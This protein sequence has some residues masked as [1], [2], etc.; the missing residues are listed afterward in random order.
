MIELILPWPP[1]INHYWRN[2][3]GRTIISREGRA[4]RAAVLSIIAQSGLQPVSGAVGVRRIIYCP[5]WRRRDIDN[6]AKA[7]YDAIGAAGLWQDDSF[8]CEEKVK[9]RK[10]SDKIGR[11][12]I[13]IYPMNT[14]VIVKKAGAWI[15]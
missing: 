10:S 5:D 11:I 8:I 9:K 1:S 7:V 14:G 3:Q 12:V 13:Q 4:Y 6:L 2:I 15:K